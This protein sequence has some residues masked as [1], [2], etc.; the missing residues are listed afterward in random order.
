MDE[1]L[2]FIKDKTLYT[3][4]WTDNSWPKR[5]GEGPRYAE[6]HCKKTF[7]AAKCGHGSVNIGK[8]DRWAFGHYPAGLVHTKNQRDL[9]ADGEV[10]QTSH[11]THV[12]PDFI[13]VF[14]SICEFALLIDKNDDGTLPHN[15]S[16]ELW[17]ALYRQGLLSIKFNARK[18]AACREGLVQHGVVRI[19]NRE[20]YS[21]KA[22]VW[23]IVL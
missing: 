5:R 18:W 6:I 16:E 14:L 10:V 17:D 1:A 23:D 2:A 20:F 22:M 21:G 8:F 9:T 19:T 12:C 13:S 15:R 7:N 4:T 11:E 3:G